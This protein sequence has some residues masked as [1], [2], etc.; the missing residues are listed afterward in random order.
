MLNLDEP[1]T[2]FSEEA[3]GWPPA[4]PAVY[5]RSLAEASREI[6]AR[7]TQ[8][9][10]DS[11]PGSPAEPPRRRIDHVL[12]QL[13]AAGDE[14]LVALREAE[15]AV[16]NAQDRLQNLRRLTDR[17]E[18]IL[19]RPEGRILLKVSPL[20]SFGDLFALAEALGGVLS[21]SDV[22]LADLSGGKASFRID[23]GQMSASELPEELSR[24]WG[25]AIRL[26]GTTARSISLTLS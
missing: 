2:P 1:D 5:A 19:A 3:D 11:A 20:A 10:P 4:G 9:A 17:L 15:A 14:A 6:R 22:T 7:V 13:T 25:R 12:A 23:L 8:L 26:T 24:V 18:E 16:A 21:D